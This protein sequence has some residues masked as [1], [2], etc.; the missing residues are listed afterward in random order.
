M[1]LVGTLIVGRRELTRSA[2]IRL[3]DEDVPNLMERPE[4]G[5]QFWRQPANREQMRRAATLAGSRTLKQ[6]TKVLDAMAAWDVANAEDGADYLEDQKRRNQ[7]RARLAAEAK[8]RGEKP[9][10]QSFPSFE[11]KRSNEQREKVDDAVRDF[12]DWLGKRIR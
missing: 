11:M 5:G 10:H 6:A 4:R 3:Y 1:T 7:E 12:H 2:R 8:A 9:S